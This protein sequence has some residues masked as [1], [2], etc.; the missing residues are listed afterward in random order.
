MMKSGW[1]MAD[2]G[3]RVVMLGAALALG[4][5]KKQEQAAP[6]DTVFTGLTVVDSFR[7][8]ESVLYDPAGDAYLV[9]NING[10]P[11]DKDDNGFI[12]RINPDG[13]VDQLTWIAGADSA[14]TLNA[15]KGMGIRGDTLFVADI[16]EVR[17]FDRVSGEPRGSWRVRGATFLNDIHVGPDG[18]V[19]VTDS[20][21]RADFSPSGSAAVWR[22][23]A[24]GSATA[25]ARGAALGGPNGIYADSAGVTVVSYGSGEAYR[26][27]ARGTRTALPKPPAGG[28]DGL[29]RASDGAWLVSSWNDSTVRRL[30]PGD[31][32][33]I[34]VVR[35]VESPAD[36]GFDTRRQRILIPLFNANR[37]RIV[38]AR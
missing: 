35:G 23:D 19:Y 20:G 22:F 14:V 9:A 37:V 16:D 15:P 25:F 31:T 13:R 27:D 1:R 12:S 3:M 8:P 29:V 34:A 30:M 10:T 11:L 38:P 5:C 26:L 32:A 33:W 7:T 18:T 28:L 4:A 24:R 2:G 21:L 6:A 17:L 36:I